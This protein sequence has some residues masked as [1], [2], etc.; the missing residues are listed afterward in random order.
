MLL[1][2]DDSI[3]EGQSLIVAFLQLCLKALRL[4]LV[5]LQLLLHYFVVLE[6]GS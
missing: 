5:L 6:Y 1:E 2:H 4:V 3:L